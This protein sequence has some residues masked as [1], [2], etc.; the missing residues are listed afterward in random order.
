MTTIESGSKI[1]AIDRDTGNKFVSVVTDLPT[2]SDTLDI[3]AHEYQNAY[4]MSRVKN[5]PDFQTES[6]IPEGTYKTVQISDIDLDLTQ[7]I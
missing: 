6:S 3:T 4:L 1:V 2:D 5:D 7:K